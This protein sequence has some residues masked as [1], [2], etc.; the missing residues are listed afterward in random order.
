M[1]IIMG[2]IEGQLIVV[3]FLCAMALTKYLVKR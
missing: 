2:I 3:L 1:N